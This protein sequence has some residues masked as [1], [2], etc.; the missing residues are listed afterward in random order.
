MTEKH[1]VSRALPT[2][3]GCRTSSHFVLVKGTEEVLKKLEE[4]WGRVSLQINWKLEPCTRLKTESDVPN[5]SLSTDATHLVAPIELENTTTDAPSES[6]C[7]TTTLGANDTPETAK[8]PN[9]SSADVNQPF[10]EQKQ[11]PQH[12]T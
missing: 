7:S 1:T 6:T 5:M 11:P 2:A 9:Q 4:E 3:S 12:S 10:L 8:T